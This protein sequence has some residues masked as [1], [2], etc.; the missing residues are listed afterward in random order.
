MEREMAARTVTKPD[1][2]I[3]DTFVKSDSERTDYHPKPS[4]KY[5][6]RLPLDIGIKIQHVL[7]VFGA[8]KKNQGEIDS[9]I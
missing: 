4:S 5:I 9:E 6:A 3:A 7:P 1:K 2:Y 8:V